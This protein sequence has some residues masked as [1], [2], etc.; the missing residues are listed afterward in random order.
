MGVVLE[1]ASFAAAWFG[2]AFLWTVAL[3]WWFAQPYRRIVLK[4]GRATVA[5]SVFGFPLVYWL[6]RPLRFVAEPGGT[7][8]W[9]VVGYLVVCW[10]TALIYLPVVSVYRAR[11]RQPAEIVALHGHVVDVAK[12]LGGKPIG[13]GKHWRMATLPGNQCFQVEFRELTVRLPRL[14]AAWDGLTVL[15]LTDLHL[16][17]TPGRPFYQQVFDL[18]MDAGTPDL[19]AITG[20]VV[21]SPHHHRWVVPLLGRLRW[22]VAAFAVLGNHDRLYEPELVRRRLR[23]LGVRVLGNGWERI[24]V[25]GD[26]LV[27]VGQEE[28][29]FRPGPD[30]S[31]CPEGPFRLCLSHTPDQ[32]GWAR[33]HGMDLVLAGHV[34]GGQ[35]RVPG[36]GSLFVPSRYSRRYD[37]GA[38]VAGGTFMYVGRGLAG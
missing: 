19:L 16:C 35:V 9:L 8:G 32:F 22:A 5:L 24:D 27:V 14:P 7:A 10:L 26:P 12:R 37:C 17:G 25:R 1:V 4:A 28:P 20:D 31:D 18:C 15:H 33:R 11:R 36:L 30:L 2:H 38:F 23:R 21:D 13:D 29:W 6:V 34:H 3:N